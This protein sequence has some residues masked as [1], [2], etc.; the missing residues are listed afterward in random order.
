MLDHEAFL[1]KGAIIALA[2]LTV[3]RLVLHEYN[4]LVSD[5][6]KRRRRRTLNRPDLLLSTGLA[7]VRLRSRYCEV[8]ALKHEKR[9]HPRFASPSRC[10]E[11]LVFPH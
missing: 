2:A 7:I 11:S 3:I 1:V 10:W 6:R 4:N 9:R 8:F 5:F